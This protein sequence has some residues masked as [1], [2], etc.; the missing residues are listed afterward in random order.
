M[1]RLRLMT[2][3]TGITRP[4]PRTAGRTVGGDTTSRYIYKS[5]DATKR[6]APIR[7]RSR[8]G[9]PNTVAGTPTLESRFVAET[10]AEPPTGSGTT[11]GSFAIGSW[12]PTNQF[13]QVD[14]DPFAPGYTYTP[15]AQPPGE[16]LY[17]QLPFSRSLIHALPAEPSEGFEQA[18]CRAF[19]VSWKLL[20]APA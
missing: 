15:L 1:P 7:I 11:V 17:A 19:Q 14:P 4:S 10:A 20:S 9:R 6:P 18:C 5:S 16:V 2:P 3:G 8:T 13:Q 12:Y